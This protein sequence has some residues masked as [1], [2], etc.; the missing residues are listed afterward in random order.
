EF[1]GYR[2]PGPG[3]RSRQPL[4]VTHEAATPGVGVPPRCSPC[5]ERETRS[6]DGRSAD[7]DRRP[8]GRNHRA[9]GEGLAHAHRA[10]AAQPLPV[11]P[12]PT[13]PVILEPLRSTQPGNE[14]YLSPGL[15]RAAAVA[16]DDEQRAGVGTG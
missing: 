7:S 3:T 5:R 12:P 4:I 15:L 9:V 11:E 10:L 1:A 8:G 14:L 16:G 6:H 13:K 2:N